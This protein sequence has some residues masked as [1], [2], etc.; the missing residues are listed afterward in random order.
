[1]IHL[2]NQMV[3]L[4]CRGN[5]DDIIMLVDMYRINVNAM[6]GGI[7]VGGRGILSILTFV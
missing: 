3:V 5:N 4:F 2:K 6:Y 7:V 1:L